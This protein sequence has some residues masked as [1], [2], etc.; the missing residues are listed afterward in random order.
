M[1][2]HTVPNHRNNRG[3]PPSFSEA[4][5]RKGMAAWATGCAVIT[6]EHAGE[7][8][9]MV[10]NS[11]NAVSLDPLL[12]SWCAARTS[13]SIEAWSEVTSW[14]VHILAE[15]Q[16]A[17]VEKF[18]RKG[19]DKFADIDTFTG[20]NGAPLLDG[21]SVVLE[22]DTWRRYDGGDHIILVGEVNTLTV[23]SRKSLVQAD[24]QFL[25]R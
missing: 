5:F 1:N 22:C 17:L 24:G 15:D 2:L 6:A 3:T 9:A 4:E 25:S 10:C 14:A 18:S 23:N 20:T 19:A 12:V 13:S 11:F 21:C 8:V 7:K 16:Q